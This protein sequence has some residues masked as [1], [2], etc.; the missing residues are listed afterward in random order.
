MRNVTACGL[1][2]AIGTAV[3]TLGSGTAQAWWDDSHGYRGVQAYSCGPPCG[4]HYFSGVTVRVQ[5]WCHRLS[6][7]RQLHRHRASRY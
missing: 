4:G 3:A 2:M 1:L 6:I 5:E 7:R